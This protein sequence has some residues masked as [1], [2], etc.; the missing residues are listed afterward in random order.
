MSYANI[1]TGAWID[2]RSQRWKFE[3]RQGRRLEWRS[4]S[5]FEHMVFTDAELQREIAKGKV[6]LFDGRGRAPA[7]GTGS[8]I[9]GQRK[10]TSDDL[11]EARRKLVYVLAIREAGMPREDATPDDWQVVIDAVYEEQG[12]HWKRL[13]GGR[14]GEAVDQPSLKSVRR[15]VADGG[16]NPTLAKLTPRHRHKGNYTDRIDPELRQLISEKVDEH[17]LKR[18]PITLLQLKEI[19]AGA[20]N[21]LN[22]KRRAEGRKALPAPG[23]EA[24]QASID[25]L[26]KDQVKRARYGEMAA[27]LA[28]GS[29]QAQADPEFPLDRVEL[30]ATVMDL[31]VV[32][33]DTSLPIGRPTLVVALDRCTRMVL[34]WFVTFEKPSILALMQC[35]RNAILPKDYLASIKEERGWIINNEPETFGV[36][37]VLVLD[38]ARENIAEHIARFAVRAGINR[39]EIMAGKKPWLKGAVERVIKTVS[40][41]LLHPTAGTTFHNT[42]MRLGYDPM[43]DAVCTPDDLDYGLHKFFI[44]V[45]PFEERRS[46]NGRQAIKVWREKTLECPVDSIGDIEDVAHLFGRTDQAKPGRHGINANGMQYFSDELLQVQRNAQFGRALAKQGGKLE[47][48]LDPACID[49]IHV[50]LPHREGVIHVP[51]APKWTNYARGLSLW[52]HRKI[53]EFIRADARTDATALLKAK[54]EL[55]E[56][57]RGTSLSKRG[58]LRARQIVARMEGVQRVAPAGTDPNNTVAGSE[59]H[60]G[61]SLPVPSNDKATTTVTPRLVTNASEAVAESQVQASSTQKPEQPAAPRRPRKGYRP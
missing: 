36:P 51:V 31:F 33:P 34:G 41:R 20:M 2:Y 15:W 54:I 25:G 7:T 6:R 27:F 23:V 3:R 43:K 57:M 49:T 5:T 53:R 21:A 8:R 50:R 22:E 30:D 39:V 61:R 13:R 55:M 58:G 56:I 46:L 40:E 37:R 28:Y 12:R 45:Y 24:I 10:A 1:V 16:D 29:A 19:V 4:S 35:L 32:D 18:P 52:H 42:L 11:E 60:P 17:Y 26:P 59:A 14:K 9:H 47:Y 38:R 48:H 44:D